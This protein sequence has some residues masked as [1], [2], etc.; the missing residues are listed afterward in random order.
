MQRANSL[1]KTL[2]LRKIE[3]RRR[4]GQQRMRWVDG[5]TDSNG[6]EFEQTPGD[7]EGQGSLAS[8]S[9]WGAQSWTR[10]SET[11]QQQQREAFSQ[12]KNL[13][14][15]KTYVNNFTSSWE[16]VCWLACGAAPTG[17]RASP[18]APGGAG[19]LGVRRLNPSTPPRTL[20]AAEQTWT[21]FHLHSLRCVHRLLRSLIVCFL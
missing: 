12:Q 4:R 17:L 8:Y 2:M 16:T 11:E 6:H 14:F 10:L 1:E 15:I 3:S 9:P 21:P 18:Q 19:L 5:I 20:A 13:I 7:S